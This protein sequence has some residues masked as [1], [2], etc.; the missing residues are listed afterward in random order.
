MAK[1][2]EDLDENV[3]LT[4][5]FDDGFAEWLARQLGESGEEGQ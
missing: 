4:R 3:V 1:L 5:F 2:R